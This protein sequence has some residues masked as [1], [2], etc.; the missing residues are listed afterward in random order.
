M[1][2]TRARTKDAVRVGAEIATLTLIFRKPCATPVRVSITMP[3][4]PVKG[5]CVGCQHDVKITALVLPRE[6][7][8]TK[9]PTMVNRGP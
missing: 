5:R 9:G 4:L 3:H 6:R 2:K 8:G 7:G 1:F